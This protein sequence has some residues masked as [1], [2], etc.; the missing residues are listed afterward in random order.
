MSVRKLVF[1]IAKAFSLFAV[2][3]LAA[4]AA[5][6]A[7]AA[8]LTVTTT[9][10]TAGNLNTAYSTTLMAT[11]GSGTGYKWSIASGALPTGLTLAT[12]GAITGKPTL[13]ETSKFT[14][15]VVDS[16][17]DS[18]TAALSITVDAALAISTTALP[19]AHTYNAYTATL[20]AKG[21]SGTGYK[22]TL[23]SGTP[24]AGLT[25]ATT[26][27]IT[28]TV[29]KGVTSK[30]T[31]KVTDS[32]NHSDTAALTLTVDS[33]LDILTSTLPDGSIGVAYSKTLLVAGGSG[34]GYKWSVSAGTLPGGFTLGTTTGMLA[35][36]PTSVSSNTFTVKVIDSLSHTLTATFTLKINTDLAVTVSSINAGYAG[37]KYS[38]QFTASGGSG[39]GYV[40][41]VATGPLPPGLTLSST[42][43][44]AGTPTTPGGFVVGFEV[45]D[46]AGDVAKLTVS[47]D[48]GYGLS[49][50]SPTTLPVGFLDTTYAASLVAQG[51]SGVGIKW[52]A[53]GLPQGI[54]FSSTGVF[55][56]SPDVAETS[57]IDVK[58]VDSAGNS[59]S[60]LFTLIV[61][62]AVSTCTND[63]PTTALVELHG[64]YT[65]AFHRINLTTGQRSWS[66]GSFDADGLG[67]IKNGVMDTNGPEMTLEQE[68]TFTGAYTVGSDERGR[69]TMVV[70]ATA[71]GQQAQTYAFCFTLDALTGYSSNYKAEAHASVIED[72]TTSNVTSG[73]FYL[74]TV[75]PSV[76]SVKGTWV[77]GLAGRRYDY[78]TGLPDF[79]STSA[80]YVTFDGTGVVTAGEVDENKD[81]VTGAGV[82]SNKYTAQ[83]ALT[84]TYTLPS[85][86]SAPLT[87]R[88]T[89]RVEG[90]DGK[91]T[92]FIF[93]PSGVDRFELMVSDP[94]FPNAGAEP[95]VLIG[96]AFRRTGPVGSDATGLLGTTV[97]SRY[98]ITDP[99]ETT[100]G[101][102]FG[103]DLAVWDGKGN[104]TYSGDTNANGAVSTTSGS[105]TYSV[106]ANGRFAVMVNGLCS[107]CGYLNI[108]NSGFA[109]YD[110][111]DGGL[112]VLEF[113][114]LPTGGDFQ[115]SSFQ[116]SYSVGDRWYFMAGEQTNTGQL[117]S[118]GNGTITGTLDQN[119]QGDTKVNQAISASETTTTTSG[120]KGRFLLSLD[121]TTSALYILGVHEAISIPISGTNL[122]TQPILQYLHQ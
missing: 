22:W 61:N 18:A 121:G 23:E 41:S 47:V 67:N 97:R 11:G 20:A 51:G 6:P 58:V 1:R 69:M 88:G 106:D 8:S 50:T 73:D 93:Y 103:I 36:K 16:A 75:P 28:G 43:L 95:S 111:T 27:A 65:F 78:L 107:P 72:D 92:N 99:G 83:T 2:I 10:L 5:C 40:W 15:K 26:G 48:I 113:Q 7:Y 14:V 37:T 30:F 79:R 9:T 68:N 57:A 3:A 59:A 12:T 90:S 60:A 31:V 32:A 66:L 87:G 46:S 39:A 110:S 122:K 104:F 112:E 4:F 86:T 84:G 70:P 98:F 34:T 21:G 45:K 76:V 80:G 114:D 96:V 117:I 108:N 71:A 13:A 91:Y 56:G 25:L 105:G 42:G 100:E 33:A 101:P 44:L 115:L 118:K 63:H 120:S 102:G 81:G 77:F 82:L 19:I 54:N 62:P 38:M 17:S 53:T 109:I 94:G 119:T 35:G 74:Q 49:I 24:P 64:V 29:T 55:S 52:S 116:G 89:L 85:S